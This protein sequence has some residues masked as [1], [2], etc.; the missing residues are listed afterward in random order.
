MTGAP[1]LS[2]SLRSRVTTVKPW[3]RGNDE[4]WLRKGGA[5]FS[6]GRK[7]EPQLE[8]DLPGYR[9]DPPVEHRPNRAE[10]PVLQHRATR[11]IARFDAE[12][13]YSLWSPR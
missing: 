1:A 8:H 6:P 3:R 11:W 5:G 9:Q 10:A 4:V 2:Y 13:D 12:P 7:Q